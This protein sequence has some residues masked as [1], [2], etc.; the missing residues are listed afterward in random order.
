MALICKLIWVK[1]WALWICNRKLL[2]PPPFDFSFPTYRLE[3]L[4]INSKSYVFMICFH[5]SSVPFCHSLSLS[6]SHAASKVQ[7]QESFHL[8][9]SH[10][11]PLRVNHFHILSSIQLVPLIQHQFIVQ[12]IDHGRH[13]G[14]VWPIHSFIHHHFRDLHLFAPF[15]PFLCFIFKEIA[16]KLFL[17]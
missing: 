14:Q 10:L 11:P 8:I 5:L 2:V 7:D 1:L 15:C 12:K 16:W 6:L 9:L 13:H 4:A 17:C 3:V